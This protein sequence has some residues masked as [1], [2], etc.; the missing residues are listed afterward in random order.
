MWMVK[1]ITLTR[2]ALL[3]VAQIAGAIF[4]SFVVSVLFPTSFNVRTT[5]SP[6]TSTV[7]GVFIEAILTAELVFAI[8]MLAKEKH[9][10]TFMGKHTYG[11]NPAHLCKT[12]ADPYTLCFKPRS[13][14]DLHCSWRSWSASIT[15]EGEL[16]PRK[17]AYCSS[18]ADLSVDR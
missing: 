18:L 13:A 8:F 10:A 12:L 4:S 1:S 15:L 11:C 2:A 7:R 9:K 14:S 3:L 16:H 17:S 6:S 5:L